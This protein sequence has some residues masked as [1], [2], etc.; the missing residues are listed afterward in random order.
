MLV[1][2]ISEIKSSLVF[3]LCSDP[4]SDALTGLDRLVESAGW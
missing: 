1:I 4:V 3:V 2:N